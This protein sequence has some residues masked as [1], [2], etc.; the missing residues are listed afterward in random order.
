MAIEEKTTDRLT[1]LWETQAQQQRELGLEP[2]E[3]GDIERRQ[4]LGD[5]ARLLHEEVTEL[6]RLSPSYKRH[7]L[8]SPGAS[9]SAVA[10]EC[11]DVLKTVVAIAQLHGLTLDEL[12]DAFATKTQV[13]RERAAAERLALAHDSKVLCI[14]L[15]D[16]VFD[17][18]PFRDQLVAHDELHA[19]ARLVA[20][21]RTKA[22][23]YEGGRF[24]DLEPIPGAPEALRLIHSAGYMIVAITARPQWQYKRLYGDTVHSLRKHGVPFDLVLFNKDKVEAMYEHVCPAWPVAFVEDME[25]NAKALAAS[26]VRVLLYDQPHNQSVSAGPNILRVKDWQQITRLLGVGSVEAAE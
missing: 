14:D 7:L 22:E 20:S 26:G 21:E 12:V 25:R 19:P 10:E 16:V 2:S 4:T 17:L 1:W 3:L 15:D 11:V 23:F 24:R 8:R 6:G 9:S 18:G 13:V 5:L